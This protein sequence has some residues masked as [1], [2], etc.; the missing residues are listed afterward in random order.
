MV[1]SLRERL[2]QIASNLA[3]PPPL[4]H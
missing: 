1:D 2:T 3:T 4:P